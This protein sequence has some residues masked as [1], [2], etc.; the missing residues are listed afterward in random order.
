MAFIELTYDLDKYTGVTGDT[1]S[2]RLLF[3]FASDDVA[4]RVVVWV[5]GVSVAGRD[6][7][8]VLA[9]YKKFNL[10]MMSLFG[11]L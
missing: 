5:V 9:W 7:N 6:D 4:G 8:Q 3:P 11:T 10:C 2:P 1:F